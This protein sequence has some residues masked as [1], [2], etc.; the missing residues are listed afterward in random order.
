M[1]PALIR[2]VWQR[3]KGRCEYCQMPQVADEGPFEIDHIISRKWE[4]A[5]LIGRT[6]VG[7]VTFVLLR[8][9]DPLRVE[10]RQTLRV[11]PARPP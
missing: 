8:T 3:A 5:V 11:Y 10:L 6:P 9:N 4:G 2:L 7:R 1:D